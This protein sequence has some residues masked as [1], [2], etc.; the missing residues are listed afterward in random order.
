M[1]VLAVLP[2]LKSALQSPSQAA[3]TLLIALVYAA[4]FISSVVVHETVPAPPSNTNQRGLDLDQAW[5]DL[6]AVSRTVELELFLT[7]LIC[8]ISRLHTSRTHTIPMQTAMFAITC[9]DV[10]GT[11]Q[12]LMQASNYLTT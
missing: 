10:C 1:R 12:I 6:Q 7:M 4:V 8:L 2:H 9:L 5:R 3:T 11:S